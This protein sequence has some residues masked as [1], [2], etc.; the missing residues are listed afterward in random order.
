MKKLVALILA[1]LMVLMI[2]VCAFAQDDSTFVFKHGFDLDYPP[3]SYIDDNGQV[4]G[5]DVEM[6]QAVCKYYGWEYELR[7]HLVRVHRQWP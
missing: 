5:F 2:S 6:A 7:L 3:Y 4:G 1:G